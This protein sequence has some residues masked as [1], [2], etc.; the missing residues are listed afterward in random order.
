MA[1]NYLNFA[2]AYPIPAGKYEDACRIL[3][4]LQDKFK[5]G[6]IENCDS[7][8]MDCKIIVSPEEVYVGSSYDFGN[9]EHA[10]MFL[11]TLVDEL[12]LQDTLLMSWAE[13]CPKLRPNAFN[14]G[15]FA[16]KYGCPTV[17]SYPTAHVIEQLQDLADAKE[18]LREISDDAGGSASQD[19]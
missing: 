9:V 12:Q 8:H 2:G 6:E 1:N 3:R 19:A 17:W 4:E 11:R 7:D 16:V 18:A 10:E 5:N 14:G 15:A 13:W